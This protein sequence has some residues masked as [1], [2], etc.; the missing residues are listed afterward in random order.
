LPL[1][2]SDFERRV[3]T[4][5]IFFYPEPH[6]EQITLVYPEMRRDTST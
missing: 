5:N 6:I 2:F 1:E 3:P 4:S